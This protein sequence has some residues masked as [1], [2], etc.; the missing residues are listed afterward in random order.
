VDETGEAL[1]AEY[2]A[3][4]AGGPPWHVYRIDVQEASA[5]Q[6]VLPGGATTWRF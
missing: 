6:T 5:L 2:S 3:P 1:T 4:S